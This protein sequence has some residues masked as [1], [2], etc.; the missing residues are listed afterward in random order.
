MNI[1]VIGAAGKS[2]KLVVERALAAGH[3]LVALVRDAADYSPPPGV[4]VVAGDATNAATLDQATAGVEAVIDT[5][6]GK[7]P[8]LKTELEQSIAKAVLAAMERNKVRRIIVISALGVGDSKAQGTFFYDHLLLPTFLRGSTPDKEAM[9][10]AVKASGVDFVLVRPA[11][12]TDGPA[13]GGVHVYE[14]QEKAHKI[15]RADVAQFIVD[16]LDSDQY[17][18]RAVTIATQ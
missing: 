1:L 4:R 17:L 13:T 16:Q 3:K 6:G 7:T 15:S 14:G 18:G 8:F 12:L 2:G 9:E 11:L 5:V 10:Q